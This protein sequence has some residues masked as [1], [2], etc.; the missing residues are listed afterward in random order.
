MSD[1]KSENFKA[2]DRVELS[3]YFD[4]HAH[5]NG[6]QLRRDDTPYSIIP[7]IKKDSWGRSIHW[8]VNSHENRFDELH[9]AIEYVLDQENVS[10]SVESIKE[11]Y[12][13]E[14]AD[15]Q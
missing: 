5:G 4:V 10:V 7:V 13:M 2:N 14:E 8:E 9:E 12:E 1:V 11:Y 3:G 15:T 6:F